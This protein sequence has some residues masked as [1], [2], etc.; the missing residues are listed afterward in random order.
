M[1]GQPLVLKFIVGTC[2]GAFI[3]SFAV[4]FWVTIK[5][6]SKT[7]CMVDKPE[8]QGLSRRERQARRR[9]RFDR[10]YV[11]DEFRS[12]RKAAAIAWT[13]SFLSFGSI[14]LI[15]LLFGERASH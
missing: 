1:V 15:G 14:V 6:L 2:F 5:V 11:A 4:I 9:S 13:S 12:L 7:G 8:D 10:Y 3:V